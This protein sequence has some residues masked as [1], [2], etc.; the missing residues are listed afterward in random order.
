MAL[1]LS[2]IAFETHRVLSSE[3]RRQVH[4]LWETADR[5][6]EQLAIRTAE[7]F[8]RVRQST[9][10]MGY[11]QERRAGPTLREL[12]AHGVLAPDLL[13]FVYVTDAEGFVLETTGPLMAD[14][15]ADEDFF[16]R[17]RQAAELDAAIAPVWADPIGGRQGIPV[18]RRLQR[19]GRFDGIVTAMVEPSALSVPYAR[20][21]ASGTVVGILGE[22]GIYRSRTVGT[23]STFGERLDVAEL[24]AR[25]QQARS[26]AV[27]TIS[28]V[29]GVARITSV[30]KVQRYPLYAIVAYA[31]DEAL[32]GYGAMRRATLAQAGFA[33]LAVLAVGSF[34]LRL[35]TNLDLSRARS[36][37]ADA[38]LRATLDG[39]LDAVVIVEIRRD[40][41]HPAAATRLVAAD[42]NARAAAMMGCR[43]EEVPG[44]PLWEVMPSMPMAR[45]L[46]LIE[47]G[48]RTRRPRSVE[49]RAREGR[50]AGRWLHHRLVPLD[51]GAALITRDI[52]EHKS[53]EAALAAQA[54]VDPLTALLNRRGFEERLREALARAARSTQ[55]L[56]LFYLDLD[57]FKQINDRYGHAGGDRVLVEVAR[58][59]QAALRVTDTVSRL[60]GDE[61]TVILEGAGT[62]DQVQD[63]AQRVVDVL[64]APHAASVGQALATPSIGVALWRRGEDADALCARA[65]AAMY[66]AK[67]AGK[68]RFVLD[69]EAAGAPRT[70]PDAAMETT[71]WSRWFGR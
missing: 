11:L 54:R 51:D 27:P 14:N 29:D 50:L 24:L 8:D 23:R 36:R 43:R 70:A 47:R 38:A 58:R 63:L 32:A 28:R 48:V 7:V 65:D 40:G 56:A 22:D 9:R 39:S 41:T 69:G 13:Q 66:A 35:A 30:V 46:R 61:F 37:K 1:V 3:Y 68:S 20:L 52:T 45:L 25:V 44:R 33:A 64:R 5:T 62:V 15:V 4:G 49:V 57:G 17:H 18:T 60:G 71:G 2:V 26:A 31:A 12:N 16:K 59:L 42:C 67:S 19:N 10:L 6:A 53:A 21:Q 34:L 55:T